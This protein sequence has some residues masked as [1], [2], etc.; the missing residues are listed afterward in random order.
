MHVHGKAF[1]W[2]GR[3]VSDE[4]PPFRPHS[5]VT[6]ISCTP[7]PHFVTILEVSFQEFSK[8]TQVPCVISLLHK[9][10]HTIHTILH[11]FFF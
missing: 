1:E 4:S 11:L 8:H 5:L 10:G 3:R 7:E 6:T 2:N 9:W